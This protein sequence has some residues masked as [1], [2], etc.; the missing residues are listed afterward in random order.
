MGF[1]GRFSLFLAPSFFVMVVWFLMVPITTYVL[2]PA[3]IGVFGLM[4][5]LTAAG[6]TIS[7]IGS[8]AVCSVHFPV[9][10]G[11]ERSR[12]VSTLLV[13]ALGLGGLFCAL[14]I[15][16][17][18]LMVRWSDGYVDVPQLGLW[19]SMATVILGVP[20]II[21][22][23]VITLEGRARAFAVVTVAQAVTSATVTIISLYVFDVGVLALFLGAASGAVVMLVGALHVLRPYLT[24]SISARWVR[25]VAHVGPANAFA[26]VSE[27]LQTAI[28]RA[29]LAS[30]LGT[31]TLGLY[32]HA[33]N[34]RVLVAQVLKAAAR[35]IWP[36]T[37]QEARQP[38]TTFLQTRIVWD[39][40]Y[41]GVA[42]AGLT[43]IAFG[44][45]I[46][47]WL[48]HGRFVEAAGLVPYLFV[49]L[50]VQNAG[51]AQT[52][53]LFRDGAVRQYYWVQVAANI[54]WFVALVAFVRISGL[55]GAALALILQQLVGR[56]GVMVLSRRRGGR[57]LLGDEWVLGGV[58]IMAV[59]MLLTE[60][61][62]AELPVRT[63]IWIVSILVLVAASWRVVRRF[64]LT[65]VPRLQ[66]ANS[67]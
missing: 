62:P 4:T 32:V 11:S 51:K 47:G 65:H 34:Y 54:A 28:E 56:S 21:A 35:P 59:S 1:L 13:V 38:G 7:L 12:L 40:M 43:F 60:V 19:L 30:V 67:L 14:C 27:A 64:A 52:G 36:V 24:R 61:L 44:R 66:P 37:L 63:A 17:W 39:V 46:I 48:T 3:A 26:S 22:Q 31:A 45:E 42:A 8:G 16:A 50:L 49:F 53:L 23:D 2:G 15:A 33:Q 25:E 6:S 57:A 20:W 58:L 18:P 10:S 55:I 5:S 9:L 29:F 41:V